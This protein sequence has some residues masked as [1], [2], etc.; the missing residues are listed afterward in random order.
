MILYL[1][2]YFRFTEHLHFAFRFIEPGLELVYDYHT[3]SY[4]N[5]V[6][7]YKINILEAIL[8]INLKF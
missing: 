2:F 7:R 6:G 5:R 4:T 1:S 8:N 3:V